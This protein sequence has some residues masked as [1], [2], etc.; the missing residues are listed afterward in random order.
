MAPPNCLPEHFPTM[1][2]K[3]KLGLILGSAREHRFCDTVAK[4]AATEIH[5][6]NQ[7][8]VDV[9]DPRELGGDRAA[10]SRRIASADAFIVVTPEYNHG[11]TGEL[12]S[13][14]DACNSEW[15]F[16]P[17]A[18]VSYGGIS[19][20]LRAIEQLRLVFAELHVVSIRDTVSFAFAS[21]RFDASGTLIDP[22]EPKKAMAALLARL[23]WW[24]TTL[25]AARINTP[26]EVAA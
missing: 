9:I 21:K 24:A 11:Y 10:L 3:I 8:D 1:S 2:H 26:F 20:G 23:N 12:K 4:W 6:R 16:K 14:I 18:F 17:L 7:F 13:L 15:H 25:R 19:G 5:G 22:A